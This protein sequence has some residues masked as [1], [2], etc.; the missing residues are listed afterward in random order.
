LWSFRNAHEI[1]HLGIEP[2]TIPLEKTWIR[3]EKPHEED[4]TPGTI[5]PAQV[6]TGRMSAYQFQVTPIRVAARNAAKFRER[7]NAE[8]PMKSAVEDLT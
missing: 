7:D 2:K 6:S 5:R 4:L 8:L 3:R 1:V